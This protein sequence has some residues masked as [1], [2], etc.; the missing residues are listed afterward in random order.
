MW[1]DNRFVFLSPS[2]QK[3]GLK[4]T[5]LRAEHSRSSET[6]SERVIT[7][8]K[9]EG[10]LNESVGAGYLDRKWPVANAW[11]LVESRVKAL[12]TTLRR[13]ARQW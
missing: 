6:L 7:R 12:G 11:W 5:D 3:S 13:P 8:L 9:S 4:R 2:Q 1:A 10:R